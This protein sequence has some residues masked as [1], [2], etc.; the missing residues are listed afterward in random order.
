MCEGRASSYHE[1]MLFPGHLKSLFVFYTVFKIEVYLRDEKGRA[2]YD[3]SLPV[4]D[5]KDKEGTSQFRITLQE[6]DISLSLKKFHLI[7][8]LFRYI[9]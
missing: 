2:V 8:Q 1:R 6:T 5:P 4:Y 3:P 7:I 9:P